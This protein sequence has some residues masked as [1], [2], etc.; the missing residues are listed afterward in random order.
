MVYLRASRIEVERGLGGA[1][2]RAEAGF[3]EHLAQAGLA[4]LGAEAAADILG[5]RVRRADERRRGVEHPPDRVAVV[6]EAVAGERLDEQHGAVVGE[7]LEAW[8]AAP[9]G[10]PMSWRQSKKQT[11]SKPVSSY[12]LAAASLN[13]TRSPTPASAARSRGGLDRR[14]VEVEADEAATFGNASAMSTVEAPWPQPT[15]ATVAPCFQLGGH[16]VQRRQPGGHEVRPVARAEEPFG[17]VEQTRV[18]IAPGERAVAA[19]RRDLL[20]LVEEQRGQH[21]GAA[22]HVHRRVLDGQ[23]QRL[24]LGQPVRAVLVLDVAR[25]RLGVQPLQHEPG[26]AARLGRQRLGT[27]PACHRPSPDTGRAPRRRTDAIIAAPPMSVTNWPMNSM[28]LDS[29]MPNAPFTTRPQ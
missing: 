6:L 11:R 13:A 14:A 28:S 4:G 23:R 25:G 2:E 7:R 15:S 29:S 20:V 12:S 3:G 5:Q 17:A 27:S 9:T 1:A 26:M 18:V 24:L 21:A 8:R 22:G 16:P 10:S 19:H